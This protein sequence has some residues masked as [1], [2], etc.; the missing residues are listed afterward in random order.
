[1]KLFDLDD[2]YNIIVKA[3]VFLLKD[4]KDL[5]KARKDSTLLYQELG[6]IYYFCDLSSD[7]QFELNPVKREKDIIKYVGL[8]EGWIADDL[9]KTCVQVYLYLSQ[10]VS[11]R[12]LESAYLA[13]D[14]FIKQ[15]EKIDL[16]E[17]D[18]ANKPIWNFKQMMDSVKGIPDT[19]ENIRKAEAQY[20]K[21]AEKDTKL[22]GDKVKTLY[23]DG[24]KKLQING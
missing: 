4:F 22:R 18:K 19:M 24:F 8:P 21:N 16:N 13:V 7:F 11:S 6:Y 10:T 17:R 20:L 15:I 23:E 2:S 5:Q 9:V 14:K 12:L 1:M 3:E